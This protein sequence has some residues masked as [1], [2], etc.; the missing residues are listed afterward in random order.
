[1]FWGLIT[2]LVLALPAPI[3]QQPNLALAVPQSQIQSQSQVTSPGDAQQQI[4]GEAPGRFGAPTLPEYLSLRVGDRMQL[5]AQA[6]SLDIE[7]HEVAVG[8]SILF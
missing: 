3:P 5:D 8:L 1:M 6:Y 4:L 2:S 7:V